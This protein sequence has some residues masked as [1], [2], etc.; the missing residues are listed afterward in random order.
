MRANLLSILGV[1][2]L[3]GAPASAQTIGSILNSASL[4]PGS[5]APGEIVV[6]T[7]TSLGPTA[8]AISPTTNVTTLPVSLSGTK[9][10]FNGIAAPIVYVSAGQLSVQVPYGLAGAG[11]AAVIVSTASGSSPTV[12]VPVAATAPALFTLNQ[13]GAGEVVALN[14]GGVN[15]TQFPAHPGSSV[16]L[17]ATGIGLTSPVGVDGMIQTSAAFQIPKQ[18]ISVT[19]GGVAAQ[20]LF[21]GPV[22]GNIAGIVQ[23]GVL[24]PPT[25]R[26][27]TAAPISLTIGGVTSTQPTTLVVHQ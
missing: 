2:I 8:L 4:L 17:Y 22:P 10:T 6:I 18:T 24:V 5:V 1:L 23:I 27:A 26:N 11:S 12:S 14:I 16:L 21:S 13:S 9:V 3:I 7:G 15:S 19:I 20:V 25:L